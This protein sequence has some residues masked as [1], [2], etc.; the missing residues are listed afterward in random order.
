MTDDILLYVV[1]SA[2]VVDVNDETIEL[3]R[4]EYDAQDL[5]IVVLRV[6]NDRDTTVERLDTPGPLFVLSIVEVRLE[7]LEYCYVEMALMVEQGVA[8]ENI[9]LIVEY[10]P[11][12]MVE[13]DDRDVIC[14][15][16]LPKDVESVESETFT[17]SCSRIVI[18][19]PIVLIW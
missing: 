2:T 6:E 16:L 17:F 5:P 10:T 4:F 14:K 13:N 19:Y 12:S 18:V 7:K 3:V 15:Q 1:I 11:G 9:L 8:R